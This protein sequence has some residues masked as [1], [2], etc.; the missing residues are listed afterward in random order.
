VRRGF[1]L[2]ECMIVMA[3]LSIMLYSLTPISLL[4]RRGQR[5][6]DRREAAREAQ[7]QLVELQAIDFESLPPEVRKVDASGWVQLGQ[8]DLLADSVRLRAFAS[9]SPKVLQVDAA[10]G[11][12]EVG[13]QLAG[14]TVVVDYQ[15]SLP[16]H[17][18]VCPVDASPPYRAR[19]PGKVRRITQVLRPQGN[20]LQPVK[21]WT[22]E[23]GQGLRTGPQLAG[24]SVIVDY[25]PKEPRL[26]VGGA[27][28]DEQLR[29]SEAPAP[30]KI[31]T[32]REP[33]ET[34]GALVLSCLRM[35]GR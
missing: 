33:G 27:F 20:S 13:K 29:Q 31:M 6:W 24:R 32:L 16:E 15:F 10:Q 9:S 2:I 4:A 19:L 11:R 30:L 7:R 8:T 5:L 21:G 1:S 17:N 28:A 35:N 3:I 12:V 23:D 22:F 14:Q 25:L 26:V 34:R 18:A